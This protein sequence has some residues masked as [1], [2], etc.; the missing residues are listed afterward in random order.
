[1]EPAIKLMP[2]DSSNASKPECVA[3]WLVRSAYATHGSTNV[4]ANAKRYLPQ[5]MPTQFLWALTEVSQAFRPVPTAESPLRSPDDRTLSDGE[6]DLLTVIAKLQHD[7][8]A[9]LFLNRLGWPTTPGSPAVLSALTGLARVLLQAQLQLPHPMGRPTLTA[10]AAL[11]K[12]ELC[13]REQ[14]IIDA[15]RLWVVCYQQQREPLPFLMRQ[16]GKHQMDELAGPLHT[17]M[18]HTSS[19]CTRKVRINCVACKSIGPDEARLLHA[20]STAQRGHEDVA[21]LMLST[22]L[23]PVA[24]R[25]VSLSIVAMADAL[26]ASDCRLPLRSWQFPELCGRATWTTDFVQPTQTV[27]H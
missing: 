16:L 26:T 9:L 8:D 5:P 20:I 25:A 13:N 21:R 14:L 4:S 24:V 7:D 17:L 19:V 23:S 15:L 11:T 18:M 27:T 3:I 6:Y 10:A 2:V 22:W 12:D 1:M